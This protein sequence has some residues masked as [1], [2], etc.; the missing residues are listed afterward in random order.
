MSQAE[1]NAPPLA[2]TTPQCTSL[3]ARDLDKVVQ[4]GD[5]VHTSRMMK[6]MLDK[7]VM[8]LRLLDASETVTKTAYVRCH[9]VYLLELTKGIGSL[10]AFSEWTGSPS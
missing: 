6:Y 3:F 4:A 2:D 10:L 5:P 1:K 9:R 8:V 7:T